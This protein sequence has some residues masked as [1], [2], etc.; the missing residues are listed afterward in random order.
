MTA[1]SGTRARDE[2]FMRLALDQAREALQV[3]EVPVGC[4]AV[5]PDGAVR[6][7]ERN[8]TKEFQDVRRAL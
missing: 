8:H 4:V 7:A 3:G 6:A 1:A 2:R 5:A